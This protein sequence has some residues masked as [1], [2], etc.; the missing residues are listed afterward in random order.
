MLLNHTRYHAVML[1]ISQ[2]CDSAINTRPQAVYIQYKHTLA[3]VIL[4]NCV[5]VSYIITLYGT[6]HKYNITEME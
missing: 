3:Y 2:I 4:L 6:C 5:N 1:N